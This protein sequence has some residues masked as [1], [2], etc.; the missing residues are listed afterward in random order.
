[1]YLKIKIWTEKIKL[2][3]ANVM[4][5]ALVQGSLHFEDQSLNPKKIQLQ[6]SEPTST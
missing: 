4:T 2:L 5:P 1:M 6:A 3:Y